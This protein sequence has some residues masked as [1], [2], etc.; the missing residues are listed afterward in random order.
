MNIREAYEYW[1]HMARQMFNRDL[2]RHGLDIALSRLRA[3]VSSSDAKWQIAR[4]MGNFGWRYERAR[5]CAYKSLRRRVETG[6][7]W[8]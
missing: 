7:G 8:L 1:W 2:Q 6:S 5:H 4:E 3:Y